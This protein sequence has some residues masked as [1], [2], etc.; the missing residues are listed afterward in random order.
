MATPP[1]TYNANSPSFPGTPPPPGG[2][3]GGTNYPNTGTN[4]SICRDGETWK[5]GPQGWGCYS[6]ESKKDPHGC[7]PGTHWEDGPV[8]PVGGTNGG[9]VQ[10]SNCP[11]DKPYFLYGACRENPNGIECDEGTRAAFTKGCGPGDNGVWCDMSTGT[12]RCD[13]NAKPGAGSGGGNVPSSG[14]NLGNYATPNQSIIDAYSKKSPE[15]IAALQN[16]SSLARLLQGQGQQIYQ[17]GAPAYAQAMQYYQ[18]LLSG[19][20]NL[21]VAAIAP[22]AMGITDLYAGARA[23]IESGN[24]RGGARDTALANLGQQ[25][26]SQI[27]QLIPQ[28]RQNAAA[29]AGS[30]GLAG[31]SLGTGLEGNS[32]QLD[33]ALATYE[34]QNRQFAIGA[35][36]SN[37][38]GAAQIALSNKSLD[39]QKA[40]GFASLDLQKQL[41][42]AG[43]DASKLA[44]QAS[45]A[46]ANSQF[47]QSFGL[48][49]SY[50]QLAQQQMVQQQQQASG[51]KWGGL[52]GTLIGAGATIYGASKKK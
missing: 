17:I 46:Q 14:L 10:D 1:P 24:L 4:G 35:E 36:Q 12:W 29:A 38:F 26:T 15:E 45:L 25:G 43:I 7:G 19:D 8:G 9:C 13:P 16:V 6:Q 40:L 28:A 52:L 48:Q 37:R 39:L 20:K 27:A 30:G 42:F 51:A 11:P 44:S 32:A 3:T 47:Q 18:A 50:L 22:D 34:G 5:N 33:Q 21:A 2:G 49:Q 23:G 41:G 31:A